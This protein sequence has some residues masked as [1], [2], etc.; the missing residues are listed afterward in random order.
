MPNTSNTPTTFMASGTHLLALI[1]DVLDLSKIEAGKFKLDMEILDI[2]PVA[3]SCIRLMAESAMEAGIELKLDKAVT[4]CKVLADERRM[5][6]VMLNL[7]TNAIKFTPRGGKVVVTA[8]VANDMAELSVADTGIGMRAED[9]P[10]ALAPFEQIESDLSRTRQ[11]T[12]LGLPLTKNL[13][14]LH[15][16]TLSIESVPG[17]GTTVR[18]SLPVL[19]MTAAKTT[20]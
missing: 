19:K 1:N 12:G 16:G 18:V 10:R 11:G 15:N 14:E 7:V 2:V 17:I 20:A 8:S 4:G 6:Q 13:V 5:K 9:I 3:S